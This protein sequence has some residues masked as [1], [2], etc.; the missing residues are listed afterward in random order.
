LTLLRY[1]NPST[2]SSCSEAFGCRQMTG[3]FFS[4]CLRFVRCEIYQHTIGVHYAIDGCGARS[5]LQ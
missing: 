3:D 5:K 4:R 2:A 1:R